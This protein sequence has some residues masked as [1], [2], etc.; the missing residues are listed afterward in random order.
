MYPEKPCDLKCKNEGICKIKNNVPTCECKSGFS[1]DD[2]GFLSFF[3]HFFLV[4][5]IS[6][7]FLIIVLFKETKEEVECDPKCQNDGKC[8]TN[9]DKDNVCVCPK[10]FVGEACGLYFSIH[11][12]KKNWKFFDNFFL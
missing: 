12:K 11:N 10:G 2:C 8:E 5:F 9:K 7:L 4:L 1:G 3:F 6:W